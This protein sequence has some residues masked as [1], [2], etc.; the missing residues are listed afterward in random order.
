[1]IGKG[2]FVQSWVLRSSC[3]FDYCPQPLNKSNKNFDFIV[4]QFGFIPVNSSCTIVEKEKP[5]MNFCLSYGRFFLTLARS[6]PFF[7]WV[8]QSWFRFIFSMEIPNV[9]VSIPQ[10]L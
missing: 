9:V 2:H 3:L 1:M 4:A 10:I 8:I 7:N 5:L 6:Y